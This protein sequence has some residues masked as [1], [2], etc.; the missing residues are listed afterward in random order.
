MRLSTHNRKRTVDEEDA[1]CVSADHRA[2]ARLRSRIR[3]G[4]RSPMTQKV[5]VNVNFGGQFSDRSIDIAISQPVYDETATVTS[6]TPTSGGALSTSAPATGYGAISSSRW[7]S[8]RSATRR[9][10]TTRQPCRIRPSST[11]GASTGRVDELKRHEL[12]FIRSWC[13]HTR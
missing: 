5:F 13:G 1:T 12:G 7:R 10:Q 4:A 6:S 3:A 8:P 9:K 11:P 2:R